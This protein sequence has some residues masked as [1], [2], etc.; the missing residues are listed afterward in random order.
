LKVVIDRFEGYYAVCEKEDCE[1]IDIHRSRI[2][3]DAK[4]GDVLN[5]VDGEAIIDTAE[6]EKRK[7]EI[8][9]KTKD[10]WA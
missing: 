10:L 5:V 4:E 3:S 6:T 2:P 7:S 8:E 9:Q 1:I